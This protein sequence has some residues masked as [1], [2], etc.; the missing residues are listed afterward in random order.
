MFYLCGAEGRGEGGEVFEDGDAVR[1]NH[2][3]RPRVDLAGTHGDGPDA[4]LLAITALEA[5][6]VLLIGALVFRR[7]SPSFAEEV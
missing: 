5:L 6:I 4:G 3:K 1:G 7:L 2:R